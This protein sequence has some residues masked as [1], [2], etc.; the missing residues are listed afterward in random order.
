MPTETTRIIPATPETTVST[1]TCNV[2][3][4]KFGNLKDATRCENKGVVVPEFV[5]GEVVEFFNLSPR[6]WCAGYGDDKMNVQDGMKGVV[7]SYASDEDTPSYNL[8]LLP[9]WYDVLVY[10][11][12]RKPIGDKKR[13]GRI[14]CVFSRENMKKVVSEEGGF[15]PLCGETS[16]E[17][18]KEYQEMLY[19]VY[20]PPVKDITMCKCASKGCS[21][22]FLTNTQARRFVGEINQEIKKKGLKIARRDRLIK[23]G[24]FLPY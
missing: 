17:K 5:Y 9:E 15:C 21:V 7:W 1:F 13:G 22:D 14:L 24:S 20:Y 23:E 4:E 2:C 16:G 8:H 12:D 6:N 19:G 3:H 11:P 10:N 18:S